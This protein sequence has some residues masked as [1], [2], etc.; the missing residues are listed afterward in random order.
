MKKWIVFALAALM[1]TGC[2]N[3]DLPTEP[4]ITGPSHTETT[5]L[6]TVETEPAQEITSYS[7]AGSDI[8][9]IEAVGNRL[10]LIGEEGLC[11]YPGAG[12]EVAMPQGSKVLRITEDRIA[13][14]WG[15]EVVILNEKLQ[16]LRRISFSEPIMGEPAL[17]ADM[18]TVYY[19]VSQGL[20]A[21][22]IGTGVTRLV[23][24]YSCR[25][26]TI[27]SLAF[28]DTVLVCR[29][30]DMDGE[31]SLQFISAE[32]G[33]TLA[34]SD[35]ILRF[36]S[37]D[38][39]YFFEQT[40]G[41]VEKRVFGTKEGGNQ[42]FAPKDTEI[43]CFPLMERN[44]VVTAGQLEDFGTA[45]ELYDLQAGSRVTFTVLPGL[46]TLTDIADCGSCLWVLG[47]DSEGGS[48]LLQWN[49]D[50]ST[51]AQASGYITENFTYESPDTQGLARCQKLAEE[52]SQRYD[53]DISIFPEDM[54]QPED[55]ELTH[56]YMVQPLEKALKCL[57]GMLAK[58]PEG[59]LKKMAE[60]SEDR[61]FHINLVRQIS[62]EERR[63]Q[64]WVDGNAYIAVC[65]GER[66]EEDCY[67]GL[68]HAMETFIFSNTSYFDTWSTNNPKKF[69]YDFSYELYENRKDTTYLA[70]ED[71]AFIDSFSMTYPKED[72]A[73]FFAFAMMDGCE[74][75]FASPAMQAKLEH[76]CK[77]IRDAMRWNK[78]TGEYPWEQYLEQSL[79]YVKK[80]K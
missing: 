7:L 66:F 38:D 21:M 44:A 76:L 17:S 20:R 36:Y 16:E 13:C 14:L 53:V 57:D 15:S 65:L 77:A 22:D 42:L 10:L 47:T 8:T 43:P 74:D 46:Q 58:F 23:K 26:Q 73:Q 28:S 24:E 25:N 64:Y 40:E 12:A 60:H 70:G 55:Y 62:N 59:M 48:V 31:S 69:Q 3:Q 1:L 68:C 79:A 33:Q 49:T 9:G 2:G 51:Q 5:V 6:P 61:I 54:V 29:V 50:L 72:R 67:H 18:K 78:E 45:A 63:I 39:R 80:K 41:S 71:R 35:S 19:G 75:V 37:R 34:S 32:N 30:E 4:S 27:C 11:F 52:I 56:E